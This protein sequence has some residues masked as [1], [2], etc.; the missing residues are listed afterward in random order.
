M[1][2]FAACLTYDSR[3]QSALYFLSDSKITWGNSN[4][5]WNVS[6][7]TF[8]SR[9]TPNIFAY[10][11]SA[12][13]PTIIITQLIEQIDLGMFENVSWTSEETHS[14]IVNQI[15][16][17]LKEINYQSQQCFT[18]IHGTR[19]GKGIKPDFKMWTTRFDKSGHL[20]SDYP[21]PFY[22]G[23]SALM[24]ITGTG[25]TIVE[26]LQKS[27]ECLEITKTSRR[28]VHLFCKSLHEGKDQYSGGSP[29]MVGLI[30][31]KNGQSYGFIWEGKKYLSGMEV[32]DLQNFDQ[33]EWRNSAFERCN[34]E[35]GVRLKTAS[36]HNLP[37][38]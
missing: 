37:V 8:V 36:N 11:G 19:A 6:R 1:T 20:I 14:K 2:S 22:K 32:S 25:Q 4:Y 35:T 38:Y 18:I 7:K 12:F 5:S 34:G 33:I 23:Y 3:N 13:I 9:N 10:V 26:E 17:S 21:E 16:K 28:A 31:I 29:Q 15:E 24:S 30:R 27:T